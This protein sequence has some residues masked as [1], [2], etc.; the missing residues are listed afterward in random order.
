MS[1]K[2]YEFLRPIRDGWLNCVAAATKSKEPFTA[3][4]RQCE[5]FFSADVGFMWKPEWQMKNLGATI[6]SKFKITVAK[7]FELVAVVGPSLYWRYPNRQVSAVDTI[8][9]APEMFGDP[10]DPV[11]QEMYQQAIAEDYVEKIQ[12]DIRNDLMTR[13]LNYTQRELPYGGLAQHSELAITEALIKGRGCLWVNN[14]QFSGSKTNLTGCFYDTVD[15][16]LIDPDCTDPTL[17]DAKYIIRRRVTPAYELE[18]MWK[19]PKGEL[20]YRGSLESANSQAVNSSPSDEMYRQAGKTNDMIVWYEVFSKCG[21]GQRL[22]FDNNQ[23]VITSLDDAFDEVVGDYAYLAITKAVPYPL[24]APTELVRNATD[25]Q[26]K[27]MFQWP[28]PFYKDDRWPVA[29]L[30]FYR[31]PGSAWPLAPLAMGLGELMFMN[32]M[33]SM[34]CNRVYDTSR[35]IIAYLKSAAQNVESALK[36]DAPQA[37]IEIND[38][39]HRSINEIV[40]ILKREQVNFDAFKMLDMASEMFDKRTGLSDMLYGISNTQSRSAA[41]INQKQSAA[42]IRPEYMASKVEQWQSEA[43][44]LEKFCA[45]WHVEAKDIKPMMGKYGSYL[46]EILITDEDPEVVLREMKATVEANSARKPNKDRDMANMT[47]LASWLLPLLQQYAV[48]TSDTSQINAFLQTMGKAMDQDMNQWM[49]GPWSPQQPQ[50]EMAMA[51]QEQQMQAQGEQMQLAQQQAQLDLASKQAQLQAVQIENELKILDAQR[52]AQVAEAD[53]LKARMDLEKK[54]VELEMDAAK[55]QAD[56]QFQQDRH[57]LSLQQD[58][59]SAAARSYNEQQQH[60]QRMVQQGQ[61][62][63]RRLQESSIL[64]SQ[65]VRDAQ[66]ASAGKANDASQMSEIKI[67]ENQA[68]SGI[69]LR[70]AAA[71]AELARRQAAAA[72]RSARE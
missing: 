63:V 37:F 18:K 44:Q 55:R 36:S 61:D 66:M 42:A 3:I 62:T 16:L 25:A 41:D 24:N 14:Y 39:A 40:Q 1:E 17:G 71:K 50:D 49:L 43:A 45:R 7:A 35:E 6:P 12:G 56:L 8:G 48:A 11:A 58:Q 31:R 5:S 64:G 60:T 27:K 52:G 34:L 9:L 22:K 72:G 21:V 57:A 54:M 53:A 51:M 65:R 15:N 10:A 19:L 70:E 26:V 38:A 67:L 47:N 29:L 23:G 33:M 28:T 69:R 20:M 32:V 2:N 30:D 46:W 68:M 4:G 59:E 13:W